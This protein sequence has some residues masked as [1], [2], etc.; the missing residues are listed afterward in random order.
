MENVFS[1]NIKIYVNTKYGLK[2]YE[3]IKACVF[4]VHDY[5]A[6]HYKKFKKFNIQLCSNTE[7]LDACGGTDSF[8]TCFVTENEIY[9]VVNMEK[10]KK[11]KEPFGAKHFRKNVFTILLHEI[12]HALDLIQKVNKN[13]NLDKCYQENLLERHK[14][15]K[16]SKCDYEEFYFSFIDEVSSNQFAY[17]NLSYFDNLYASSAPLI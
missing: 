13:K 6:K 5:F 12:G 3:T 9:C 16:E 4:F 10:I 17:K 14:I 2:K 11:N 15:L 8:G 1:K 7:Y